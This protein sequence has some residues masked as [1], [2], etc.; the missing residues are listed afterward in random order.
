[1]SA[2]DFGGPDI[3]EFGIRKIYRTNTDDNCAKPWA[4][5]RDDWIK[6]CK[7][8]APPSQDS[9][10]NAIEPPTSKKMIL[11]HWRINPDG[12]I[13]RIGISGQQFS[14]KVDLFSGAILNTPN[15]FSGNLITAWRDTNRDLMLRPWRLEHVGEFGGTHTSL[16]DLGPH[17]II[18]QVSTVGLRNGNFFTAIS[19]KNND[20][21]IN[22]WNAN[23]D[24]GRIS[25]LSDSGPHG[26]AKRISAVGFVD[27][28]I[29]K[30]VTAICDR[31]NR[32]V[33]TLW[34]IGA[35]GGITRLGDSF[36]QPQVKIDD[37]SISLAITHLG[38]GKFVT[39]WRDTNRDLMLRPWR[40]EADGSFTSLGDSGPH[41]IIQ[42]V[43]LVT[44][45]DDRFVTVIR[46]K[47]NDLALTT[48]GLNPD[49]SITNLHGPIT[50]GRADKISAISLPRT[51]SSIPDIDKIITAIRDGSNRLVLT[52]WGIG[53][54]GTITRLG[55][56]F[57]Q[58]G[59]IGLV[60]IMQID[61]D[62]VVTVV[63]DDEI[64]INIKHYGRKEKILLG[65][66]THGLSDIISLAGK[67]II[68][69]GRGR[70]SVY[71]VEGQ[72]ATPTHFVDEFAQYSQRK[73]R[74]RGNFMGSE[75]DWKNVEMTLYFKVNDMINS[76]TDGGPHVTLYARGGEHGT[77][78]HNPCKG[79]EYHGALAVN[80][81]A[82]LG[83]EF[84]H[85]VYAREADTPVNTRI[86]TTRPLLEILENG[87]RSEKRWVGLKVIVYTNSDKGN[88]AIET[89]LDD[90]VIDPE[91]SPS[92]LS[93][94]RNVWRQ[95]LFFEDEGKWKIQDGFEN[96][97]DGG[98][99]E[100]ITWG[101]P[102]I[103]IRWD[104]IPDIDIKYASV[105][106][107]IPP[108]DT[109]LD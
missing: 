27:N 23:L 31:D 5:G 19:D 29:D 109:F 103:E 44:L 39:A 100:K 68:H 88:P 79:T 84:Y 61:P 25:A 93:G 71:A 72:G 56:S 99:D 37:K 9:S 62:H 48:F 59:M 65:L 4:M 12:S 98:K 28:N 70:H 66:A 102:L 11:I 108:P 52:L 6:R 30:V 1:M 42:D 10:G 54:D 36:A 95:V 86:N 90:E 3:D 57:G 87:K 101:G 40:L 63:R 13:A 78:F 74:E 85:P 43:S 24:D 51:G 77:F 38:G 107:I 8:L 20:L 64:E 21:R 75:K 67:K 7:S 104:C 47:N 35:D 46:D 91:I 53:D 15:P 32:L 18:N 80:G 105:R 60:D 69:P 76:S 22:T 73:M 58:A 16:G 2:N 96:I 97:C 14:E 94:P 106:E 92:P 33:L 49:G 50:A 83:K 17:G 89:W 26:I 55:D 81:E 41:G 82:I 34:G 45:R